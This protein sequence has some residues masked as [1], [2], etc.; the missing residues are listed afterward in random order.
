MSDTTVTD[1]EA[2]DTHG[3]LTV[4][5]YYALASPINPN[6]VREHYDG[7]PWLEGADIMRWLTRIFG[8]C[9]WGRETLHTVVHAA[10]QVPAED[11]ESRLVW[12]VTRETTIRLTLHAQDGA[13]LTTFD[14]TAVVTMTRPVL[15][16]AHNDATNTA[17]TNALKRA[18]RNLS[19]VFG[20]G[21]AAGVLLKP[22]IGGSLTRPE[23]TAAPVWAGQADEPDPVPDCV[24]AGDV[25]D[26]APRPPVTAAEG[27]RLVAA[28]SR[29]AVIL[30]T[31]PI[32]DLSAALQASI[33]RA[34]EARD[35]AALVSSP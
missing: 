13:V 10:V 26:D 27:A 17:E 23:G 35:A 25:A 16:E 6:R 12:E 3:R 15:G 8:Y 14:G 11:D 34:R 4:E 1:A 9:G 20:L 5:Q 19:D 31:R 2:P 7:S 30:T 32:D 28:A 33:A 18:A 24:P 22:Y 21:L 29:R